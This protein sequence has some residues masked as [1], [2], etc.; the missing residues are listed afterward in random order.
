M[1]DAASGRNF[2]IC[3][4]VLQALAWLGRTPESFLTGLATLPETPLPK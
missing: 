3:A 4:V 1:A 2:T